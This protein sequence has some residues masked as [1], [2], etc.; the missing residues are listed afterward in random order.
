MPA[1]DPQAFEATVTL[2]RDYNNAVGK[3]LASLEGLLAPPDY[4]PVAIWTPREYT[5]TVLRAVSEL[6]C[7]LGRRTEYVNT[8]SDLDA[9]NL[10]LLIANKQQYELARFFARVPSALHVV[11]T[12]LRAIRGLGASTRSRSQ[13]SQRDLRP[14]VE[15]RHFDMRM[16]AAEKI[17]H[18]LLGAVLEE[19]AAVRDGTFSSVPAGPVLGTQLYGLSGFCAA[20]ELM[21]AQRAPGSKATRQHG[22]LINLVRAVSEAWQDFVIV[23]FD[24]APAPSRSR[25]R[26]HPLTLV[27]RP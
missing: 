6:G 18:E 19:L 7:A 8:V 12:G 26:A 1:V 23:D 21:I 4:F 2:L 20:D 27:G 25:A 22:A 24:R 13:R 17:T 3:H 11:P 15:R 10:E 5:D 14:F 9:D 16:S